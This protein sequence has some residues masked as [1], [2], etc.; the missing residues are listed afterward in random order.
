[1]GISSMFDST[2]NLSGLSDSNETLYVDD[3]IHKTTFEVD[4]GVAGKTLRI[5]LVQLAKIIV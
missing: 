1:M 5:T 4:S 3:I 2:A